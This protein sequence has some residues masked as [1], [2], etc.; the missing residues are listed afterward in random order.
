MLGS[1]MVNKDQ[2]DPRA[3]PA[4]PTV[5]TVAAPGQQNGVGA[6]HVLFAGALGAG[7]VL[8]LGGWK[9]LRRPDPEEALRPHFEQVERSALKQ[10]R[11]ADE[12]SAARDR[13]LDSNANRRIN[14]LS[15][16]IRGEQ[17][18][19]FDILS[20]QVHCLTQI[21]LQTL[22]TMAKKS[23]GTTPGE[24]IDDEA[25]NKERQKIL[26]WARNAQRESDKLMDVEKVEKA[27]RFHVSNLRADL[28][29]EEDEV[30]GGGEMD[31][32]GGLKTIPEGPHTLA[33]ERPKRRKKK[34]TYWNV[35]FGT[36]G[37]VALMGSVY[38][39]ATAPAEPAKR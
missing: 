9:W 33:D 36:L 22:T 11:K 7:V 39:L 32:A 5:F 30:T 26:D 34:N 16:D 6:S 8:I 15:S 35:A 28:G 18:A 29:L 3:A 21:A 1:K 27:R 10:V 31:T 13:M 17:R 4:Q 14:K 20:Q 24:G 12:N 19:S 2:S 23:S 25:L 38:M 37:G